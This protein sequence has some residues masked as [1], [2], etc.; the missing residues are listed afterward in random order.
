[1]KTLTA[2]IVTLVSIAAIAAVV[3][4]DS[5][6]IGASP[7]PKTVSVKEAK[8]YWFGPDWRQDVMKIM[9][10]MQ[11]EGRAAP[12]H[13][14]DPGWEYARHGLPLEAIPPNPFP[15]GTVAWDIYRARRPSEVLYPYWIDP[16]HPEY[17]YLGGDMKMERWFVA[18][19]GWDRIHQ[20]WVW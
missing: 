13:Q 5:Q 11:R 7:T 1:M 15:T 17:A 2:M 8:E 18:V 16:N 19:T 14:D 10:A 4:T 6:P 20:Q 12:P 9:E 3:Y